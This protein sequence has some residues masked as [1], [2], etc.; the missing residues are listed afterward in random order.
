MTNLRFDRIHATF[1]TSYLGSMFTL[2]AEILFA[3]ARDNPTGHLAATS[4]RKV[5]IHEHLDAKIRLK[6]FKK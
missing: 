1:I 6:E 4:S 2:L 5:D 3:T